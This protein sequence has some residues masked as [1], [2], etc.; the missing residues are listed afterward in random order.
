MLVHISSTH[1]AKPIYIYSHN[2]QQQGMDRKC[3]YEHKTQHELHD[4]RGYWYVEK[5]NGVIYKY[6]KIYIPVQYI[7]YRYVNLVVFVN[8]TVHLFHVPV[9]PYVVQLVLGL[10]FIWTFAVHSLLLLVVAINIYWFC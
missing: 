1:L 8:Y 6:Y 7:L 4:V 9:T 2:Q 10:V 5:V 3:P